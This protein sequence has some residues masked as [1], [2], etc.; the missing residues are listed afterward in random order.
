M[1]SQVILDNS[2]SLA[3]RALQ[4]SRSHGGSYIGRYIDLL[5]DRGLWRNE[6]AEPVMLA[7]ARRNGARG[8]G[9]RKMDNLP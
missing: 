4:F 9:K 7:G 6:Y 3:R 2:M 5:K 8:R 1:S